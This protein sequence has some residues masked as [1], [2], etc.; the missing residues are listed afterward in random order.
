MVLLGHTLV[1]NMQVYPKFFADLTS[2]DRLV[3]SERPVPP[4]F[5]QEECQSLL[6]L[7]EGFNRTFTDRTLSDFPDL[8]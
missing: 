5:S 1:S 4:P 8:H 6:R 3:Q 7:L 2:V